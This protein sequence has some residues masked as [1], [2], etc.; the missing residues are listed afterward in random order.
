LV[1]DVSKSG[2]RPRPV[3][4]MAVLMVVSCEL[5]VVFMVVNSYSFELKTAVLSCEMYPWSE[6]LTA[7]IKPLVPPKH[8]AN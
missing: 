5:T 1:V 6:G 7:V 3:S 2:M 4:S 8:C